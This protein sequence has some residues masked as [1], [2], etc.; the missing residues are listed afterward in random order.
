MSKLDGFRLDGKTALVTGASRGIGRACAQALAERGATVVV[1]YVKDAAAAAQV[2]E[3]I[4][5]KG[6]KAEIA[7]F[8]VSDSAAVNAAVAGMVERHG[9]VDVLVANAGIVMESLIL[10]LTDEALD[11]LWTT[12]VRGAI[13]CARATCKG[14]MKKRWGRIIFVSSVLGEKGGVGQT[15][16]AATKAALFG[17]AKSLAAE[18]APRNVTANT[19]APGYIDTDMTAHLEGEEREEHLRTIPAGRTGTAAEVAAAC[20]YL[21]SDEAGYVTG[22]VLRV[23][24]GM[25]V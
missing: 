14:M 7:P 17:A 5:S 9:S 19:I 2:A 8:D 24:G 23:N 3:S 18:L 4:A 25:Y 16:Y 10:R 1:N 11:R 21:A 20:V 15:G 22:Q 6:G 12:N 13:A